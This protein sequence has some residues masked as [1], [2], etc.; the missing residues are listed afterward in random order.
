M[1]ELGDPPDLFFDDGNQVVTRLDSSVEYGQN[2]ENTWE[3]SLDALA[4][5]C[6]TGGIAFKSQSF[7][8]AQQT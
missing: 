3:F 1:E 2:S 6:S 4:Q 5:L 7:D 8:T